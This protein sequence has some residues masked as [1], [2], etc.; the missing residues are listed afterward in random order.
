MKKVILI[1]AL[2]VPQFL[3]AQEEQ[4]RLK[5]L[6]ATMGGHA[7]AM[8]AG[9]LYDDFKIIEN[10][11]GWVNNHPSPTADLAKI[12]EELGVE[13]LRFKY[14]DTLTH[15]AANAIGRAAKKR[16][17]REVGK[18]YGIMIHNCTKCHEAYRDRLRDVLHRNEN[19]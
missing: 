2:L 19:Q 7:Q 10:A 8:L 4:P 17:M 1:F 6:M 16:D 12:K 9:I 14:Y 5:T 13:V 3:F 18:Q 15:N 11:V